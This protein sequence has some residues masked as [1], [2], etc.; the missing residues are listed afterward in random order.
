MHDTEATKRRTAG[1]LPRRGLGT[2]QGEQ[3]EP[4]GLRPRDE[5][6]GAEDARC[7]P[8]RRSL[9][10]GRRQRAGRGAA[11]QRGGNCGADTTERRGQP[12]RSATGRS[13]TRHEVERRAGGVRPGGR[14]AQR[15]PAHA[16]RPGLS[17]ASERAPRAPGLTDPAEA[18][19]GSAA[20]GRAKRARTP[21]RR[22][23]AKA[24]RDARTAA[25]EAFAAAQWAQRGPRR[26]ASAVADS[27]ARSNAQRGQDGDGADSTER[28]V[29]PELP[30]GHAAAGGDGR[31]RTGATPA[32]A[33]G[34]SRR[35]DRRPQQREDDG[36]AVCRSVPHRA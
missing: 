29:S 4:G 10:E 25:V 20:E 12:G 31:Y 23:L 33:K 36:R 18:T 13:A 21:T 34:G 28:R 22:R 1:G 15:V 7:R 32:R 3:R 26:T 19:T 16:R 27:E 17:G 2:A 6:S 8:A 11:R 30:R 14:P 5:R 35:R 9:G 24:S